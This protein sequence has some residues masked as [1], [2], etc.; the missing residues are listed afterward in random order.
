MQISRVFSTIDAHA[1]GEPLRIITAGAPLLPGDTILE[2]RQYMEE[3]HD[4]IRRV[5]LFEPRG[6]ADMY[7]AIL[8][9]PVTPE[10]DFGVL[11]LTNEGYSSMCGHGVIALTT[12]LLE[13]GMLPRA[14]ERETP[15]TYDSP[16]GLIRA[17]ATHD[18]DRVTSVRFQNVPAF[19]YQRGLAVTTSVGPVTVDVAWGGA[20]Y[21][22]VEAAALGLEVVPANAARLTGLGMEI[23]YAVQELDYPV[24]PEE[25]G[26]HGVYG[27]IITAPPR[28][29]EGDGRNITIYADGAVD[30]SPCG[31]GT[32]ARL[33]N[34]YAHGQIGVGQPYRHESVIDTIFTGSVLAETSVA[35][36]PA[37]ETEIA[38]RGFVT[39]LHQ[40]LA[41]PDDPTS[42]GFLV[43]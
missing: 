18:G 27:T 5:L 7:G 15:V 33:A 1:A 23:K 36:L 32:S 19:Q 16:A 39:G 17:V 11:F 41:Q 9:P 22:L 25:P 43:R 10:A 4:D 6:H 26:L 21:A 42:Q 40:F 24:H 13:M 8:T 38:G 2:R 30:R 35:G 29:S 31:T 37:V 28:T 14:G 20:F 12:T 3:H 34:M